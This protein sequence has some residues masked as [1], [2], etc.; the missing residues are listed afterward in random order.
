MKYTMSD[1]HGRY[2]K[3][4]IMLNKINFTEDDEL[5]L[6]G[7]VCDRG[8]EA[9]QIYLDVMNRDNIY[10]IMGNHEK[11]L[12][13]ALPHSFGF[14]QKDYGYYATLDFE[15]WSACGGGSTCGSLIKAGT[16]KIIDIYNYILSF[17]FYR[18]VEVE[19]GRKFLLVHA[20]LDNYERT[21]RLGDYLPE[22]LVWYGFDHNGTYYPLLYDRIIVG[23]TPTFLL[24]PQ[25]PASIFYGKGNVIDIDCGAVFEG[26]SDGRLACLCLDTMEEFYV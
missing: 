22:E 12:L 17:P 13:E 23:H 10:C 24:N 15:I 1:L 18:V 16:D 6:L 5:F 20:G 4:T 2:D 11:M 7:D 14:L 21:K 3:Y 8:P 9:A 19:D 25:K 26:E